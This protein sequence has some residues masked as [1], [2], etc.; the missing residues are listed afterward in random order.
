[1]AEYIEHTP[2][3]QEINFDFEENMKYTP[4]CLCDNTGCPRHGNCKLC[5]EFH[6]ISSHPSTCKYAWK[7]KKGTSPQKTVK[8]FSELK[9]N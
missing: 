3:V 7:W 4:Y 8:R 1:M 5:V 9:D 6:K 2:P